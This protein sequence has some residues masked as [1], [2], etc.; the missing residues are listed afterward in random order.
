VGE[1]SDGQGLAVTDPLD[2]VLGLVG[3]LGDGVAG[4]VGQLDV[5]EVGS[6]DAVRLVR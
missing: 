3:D 6:E 5:L 2:A 4:E 1:E